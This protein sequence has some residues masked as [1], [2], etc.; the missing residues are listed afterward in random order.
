MKLEAGKKF[1]VE[2]NF[3]VVILKD[4][5]KL[6]AATNLEPGTKL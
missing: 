6:Q 2:T 5:T 1:E 3:E 4:G